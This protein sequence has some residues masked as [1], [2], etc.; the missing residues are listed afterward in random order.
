[1]QLCLGTS[2]LGQDGPQHTCLSVC[3]C[4]GGH[5]FNPSQACPFLSLRLSLLISPFLEPHQAFQRSEKGAGEVQK[6]HCAQ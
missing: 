3:V 6:A 5:I 4:V 2:C 1:M